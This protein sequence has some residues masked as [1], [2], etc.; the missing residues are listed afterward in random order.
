MAYA[1]GK[2]QN[3]KLM[4]ATILSIYTFL[5]IGCTHTKAQPR[6]G[7]ARGGSFKMVGMLLALPSKYWE[8]PPTETRL[9]EMF[10][11]GVPENF[12]SIS[13]GG[14]QNDFDVL[15]LNGS[16]I[17]ITVGAGENPDYAASINPRGRNLEVLRRNV[18]GWEDITHT[19]LP[20]SIRHNEVA[21]LYPDGRLV[22]SDTS[23][24]LVTTLRYDGTGFKP[25]AEQGLPPKRP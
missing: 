1:F 7:E 23:G 9:V 19:V 6:I 20:R 16:S 24:T 14:A 10:P 17:A 2:N 18:N 11:K 22:V 3:P 25:N 4:K 8:S 5:L 13:T 12:V 15:R 21:K